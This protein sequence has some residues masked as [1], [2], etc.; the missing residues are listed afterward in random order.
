M[1]NFNPYITNKTYQ[2]MKNFFLLLTVLLMTSCLNEF[3]E[4]D[5][6]RNV[7]LTKIEEKY[8][9][10]GELTGK[11]VRKFESN[12]P[13]LDSY[14]DEKDQLSLTSVWSYSDNKL[15]S[16]KDYLPD[17]ESYGETTIT[18][19]NLNRIVKI[20]DNQCEEDFLVIDFLHNED[21]TIDIKTNFEGK[22]TNKIFSINED[23]LVYK[24]T[25]DGVTSVLVDYENFTPKSSKFNSTDYTFS[26]LD[27]VSVPF[28]FYNIF[29]NNKLNITLFNEYNEFP[30][31]A[32]NESNPQSTL[33][34][35]VLFTTNKLVSK[36]TSESSTEEHVYLFDEH[37]LILNKKCYLNGELSDDVDYFFAH[38]PSSSLHP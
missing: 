17:G 15:S 21:N 7:S 23:G 27:G 20:A 14:Y 31:C 6:D 10:D 22:I 5:K 32:D 11:V 36:I 1:P 34:N 19:D 25:I 38:D 29:G 3:N 37:D 9:L 35:S 12:K 2:T 28:L 26:Y 13:I 8:F 33:H 18:Y 30:F 4:I 16:I 24:E